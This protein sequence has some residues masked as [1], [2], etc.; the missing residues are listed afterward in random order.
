MRNLS[1]SD[2]ACPQSVFGMNVK[3]INPGSLETLVRY[4]WVT[5]V[6]TL[7]TVYVV[8][9]LQAHTSF[10]E[11]GDGLQKRAAWPILLIWKILPE[12]VKGNVKVWKKHRVEMWKHRV[13]M[14]KKNRRARKGEDPEAE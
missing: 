2:H 13:E 1:L 5:I 11:P 4:V 14:W 8:V 3:E 7:I 6:L 12:K 10:H 9:T